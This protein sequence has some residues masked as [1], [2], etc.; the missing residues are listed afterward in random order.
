MPTY[1]GVDLGWHTFVASETHTLQPPAL[2]IVDSDF[3]TVGLYSMTYVYGIVLVI[4][5][6]A[7]IAKPVSLWNIENVLFV[8]KGEP[9]DLYMA[10]MRLGGTF[11][12][13]AGL[14]MLIAS[15]L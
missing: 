15:F 3:D 5:G 7:M 9:S 14:A 12:T 6:V 1:V 4:L 2:C 10:L 13:L 8:N 11:F